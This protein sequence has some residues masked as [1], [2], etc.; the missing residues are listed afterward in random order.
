[1]YEHRGTRPIPMRRFLRRLAAHAAVALALVAVSLGAGMAGYM[2][3]ERLRW[4][5]AF[6][7]AAMLLGGMGPVDPPR[8][9]AGKVFAGVYALYCGI[10]F[11]AAAGIVSAPVVHRLLHRF[12]WTDETDR[13]G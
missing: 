4:R 9:D 13:R 1:M 10:V 12:H 7:N 3:L 6:L 2:S 8:S 11:L 5:D